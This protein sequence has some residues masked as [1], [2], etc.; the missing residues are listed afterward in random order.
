MLGLGAESAE[1]GAVA[2]ELAAQHLHRDRPLEQGVAGPPDPSHAA[3]GEDGL[4]LVAVAEQA[5]C[6]SIRPPPACW[7]ASVSTTVRPD[8]LPTGPG[9]RLHDRGQATRHLF[10][11]LPGEAVQTAASPLP[12]TPVRPTAEQVSPVRTVWTGAGAALVRALRAPARR[13]AAAAA[14]S[15]R[16]PGRRVGG[17]GV[18][19]RRG[20]RDRG[21]AREID[22]APGP[23]LLLPAR[24][25]LPRRRPRPTP[26]AR[27]RSGPGRRPWSAPGR[28]RRGC[29]GRRPPDPRTPCGARSRGR[30][31]APGRRPR[32]TCR[33]LPRCAA[34]RCS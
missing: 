16:L 21:P 33:A 1:E 3:A 6:G 14:A 28:W 11:P 2:G 24:E 32:P 4:Q 27:F 13:P 22:G 26:P 20:R 9:R 18:R 34:P 29:R 19:L 30:G 7:P 5:P 12:V 31:G 15:G 8:P 23:G 25:D 10:G 17:S